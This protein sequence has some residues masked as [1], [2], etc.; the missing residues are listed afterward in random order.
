MTEVEIRKDMAL[1]TMN[2]IIKM[3]GDMNASGIDM[4]ISEFSSL[5]KKSCD[6]INQAC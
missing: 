4:P 1:F 2:R 6:N 3:I 5:M